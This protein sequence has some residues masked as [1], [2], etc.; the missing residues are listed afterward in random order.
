VKV[1]YACTL[2]EEVVITDMPKVGD[3]EL[4]VLAQSCPNLASLY[5]ADCPCVSDATV[6]IVAQLCPDL[7]L[8]D[9]SRTEMMYDICI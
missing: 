9:L 4:R 1:F 8:L 6:Q 5:C 7:D 2:L 3:E